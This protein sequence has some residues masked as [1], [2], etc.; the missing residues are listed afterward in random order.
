MVHG[1]WRANAPLKQSNWFQVGGPAEWLFKP[2]DASSLAALLA[3]KPADMPLTVL[4]VGSNLII[5]DGGLPGITIRL[6]RAFNHLNIVPHP[7]GFLV[8]AGAAVL[9]RNV[10]LSAA[11]QG[12][13]GLEFMIGIPGTVGGMVAM[14]GGAYGREIKDCLLRAEL[15]LPDGTLRWFNRDELPMRY[16][17]GGLPEGAIITQAE[18][19]AC[20]EAPDTLR[21]RLN[22]IVTQR[23]TTQPIREKTGG[24]TFKNPD[25]AAS[26]GKKAW[27]LVDEAGCRGLKR[28]GAQISE[29]HCNFMINTGNATAKD[30]EEL[31]EEVRKRVYEKFGLWLEWEIKRIGTP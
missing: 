8:T 22:E 2:D 27:Q 1:S 7:A 29:K 19:L 12:A 4:G 18:F 16:R 31:G 9:G 25:A 10:A 21:T 30:L 11:D 24:S 26:L 5:R 28:G 13:G 15:A 6:G 14:N 23:E 20:H 17:F 3:Q